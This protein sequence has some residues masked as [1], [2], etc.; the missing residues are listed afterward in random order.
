MDLPD[1]RLR[2]LARGAA[3]AAGLLGTYYFLALMGAFGPVS[4]WSGYSVSGSAPSGGAET[5]A[6]PRV[7]HGCESGID[8]L[9]GTGGPPGGGNAPV[10]FSWAFALLALVALGG[11]GAWNGRRYLTWAA[12][13][14]G[15]TITVVGVFS[16]GAYFLLPTLSLLVAATALSVEAATTA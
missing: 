4:C 2:T 12:V 16:I 10:L 7:T 14:A 8:A 1:R 6:V 11:Y 3:V 15:A 5:T 9:L 13:V